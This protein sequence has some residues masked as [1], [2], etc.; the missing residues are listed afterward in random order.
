MREP[1]EA[2]MK[3]PHATTQ[4]SDASAGFAADFGDTATSSEGTALAAAWH[5]SPHFLAGVQR[6][7]LTTSTS[8]CTGRGTIV[9]R[10]YAGWCSLRPCSSS[11]W[12]PV[13]EA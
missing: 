12:H 9:Q 2:P 10:Q 11:R 6:F 7:G 1:A 8:R 5:V 4:H 3:A 13:L